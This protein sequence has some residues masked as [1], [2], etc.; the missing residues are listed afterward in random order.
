MSLKEVFYLLKTDDFLD[1]WTDTASRFLK[2]AEFFFYVGGRRRQWDVDPRV[3][4]TEDWKR[5]SE[6]EVWD[7]GETL[8][9]G[10][11]GCGQLGPLSSTL[12]DRERTWPTRT[13]R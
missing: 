2:L 8:S 13:L 9:V 12:G 5:R 1:V 3:P 6:G 4:K 11:Y 7:E 10:T